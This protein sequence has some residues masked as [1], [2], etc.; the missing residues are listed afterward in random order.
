MAS[1]RPLWDGESL[2]KSLTDFCR[3]RTPKAALDAC[4]RRPDRLRSPSCC[5]SAF[6]DLPIRQS[7]FCTE[8]V[9][10][11]ANQCARRSKKGRQGAPRHRRH[12]AA[13]AH[14]D[15]RQ[16]ACAAQDAAALPCRQAPHRRRACSPLPR[17]PA[18]VNSRSNRTFRPRDWQDSAV[19][20]RKREAPPP[21]CGSSMSH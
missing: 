11:G 6:G 9:I 17:I 13:Q 3:H 7:A 19:C 21:S 15:R 14:L 18:L 4:A 2:T 5:K 12:A 20:W 10:S 8:S 16:T 1:F